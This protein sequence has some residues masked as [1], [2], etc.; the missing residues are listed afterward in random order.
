M[1]VARSTIRAMGL[2]AAPRAVRWTLALC[3]LWVAAM[4]VDPD[5]F[6][7]GTRYVSGAVEISGAVLC[8]WRAAGMSGAERLGWRLIAAGTIVWTTADAYW[9][10]WLSSEAKIPVPSPA[11]VGYLGAAVLYFAG[12]ALLIR[13]RMPDVPRTLVA[14][15]V[16]AALAG[17]AVSAALVLK[18]VVDHLGGSTISAA[19]NLAYPVLDL[20]LLGLVLAAFSMRRWRFDRTWA[21]L[22]A[23]IASFWIAD[24]LYLVT[25]AHGTYSFPSRFDVGWVAAM[26][27]FAAAAW[28]PSPSLADDAIGE[29]PRT[30]SVLEIALPQVFGL[31]SLGVLVAGTM[32]YVTPAAVGLAAASLLCVMAR[33]AMT[34]TD[35]LGLLRVS[36]VEAMTDVLTGL[37]N[38]RALALDLQRLIPVADHEH[39][40]VL[41]LFDLDGFKAYN[42][43]YGHP[44]GD[45]LL[46]RLGARLAGA[47]SGL[48][49]AYRMGGDEFCVLIEPGELVAEPIIAAAARAL[50][51]GGADPGIGS[52][53]GTVVLPLE[54]DNPSDA[55]RIADQRMYADKP[56]G[57]GRGRRASDVPVREPV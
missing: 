26:V 38:R 12:I 51:E 53:Y 42:D 5:V 39:P 3:A 23:A 33:L 40:L 48:G 45:A 19:T 17:G 37:A 27:L 49:H 11:D 32:T 47:V 7:G 9:S 21:L 15:G 14:D 2:S 16:T 30:A 44:A 43:T 29:G 50:S 31:V 36:R 34:F 22:G 35:N 10:L 41:A 8:A 6:G 28:Q 1:S 13:H 25:N 56:H 46:A 18:V 52:T 24:S 20:I 57:R 4:M 54:A 55:L